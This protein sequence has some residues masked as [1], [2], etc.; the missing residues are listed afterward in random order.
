MPH[1][2]KPAEVPVSFFAAAPVSLSGPSA[3]ASRTAENEIVSS[4]VAWSAFLIL[5]I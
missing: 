3:A 2:C 5:T 1:G 4:K